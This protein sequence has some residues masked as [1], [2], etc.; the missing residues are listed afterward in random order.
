M[1]DK[2]VITHINV[3]LD[4]WNRYIKSGKALT[5]LIERKCKQ[6]GWNKISD[7]RN[8]ASTYQQVIE[9]MRYI[10][11]E[12]LPKIS[13]LN[14]TVFNPNNTPTS[15]KNDIVVDPDMIMRVVGISIIT[16]NQDVN[17][18]PKDYE[19]N[20]SYEVKK[21][22]AVNLVDKEGITLDH[23]LIK[24]IKMGNS[25]IEYPAWQTAYGDIAMTMYCRKAIDDN[26][27]EE[28]WVK[29]V[30]LQEMIKNNQEFIDKLTRK[31]FVASSVEPEPDAQEEGDYWF[32]PVIFTEPEPVK[33]QYF[34]QSVSDSAKIVIISDD[35]T[36]QY[37]FESVDGTADPIV[38][39]SMG[40]FM[41]EESELA[42]PPASPVP[43]T[44]YLLQSVND[45]SVYTVVDATTIDRYQLESI[46]DPNDTIKPGSL[47]EFQM[48]NV[49]VSN[50]ESSMPVTYMLQ[51]T[52][53]NG[54][55][56][57]NDMSNYQFDP[58]YDGSGVPTTVNGMS[59]FKLESSFSPDPSV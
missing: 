16:D 41:M 47:D 18:P 37:Q 36:G 44:V 57:L 20:L 31:Q 23:V 58:V 30:D 56:I 45:A 38:P 8:L 21:T 26:T 28:D 52:I 13:I 17:T 48:E 53:D 6:M 4:M 33:V 49:E 35:T 29:V 12:I 19:R 50:S 22:S 5:L 51:S 1:D 40:E 9:N 42:K 25:D 46:K 39:S 27:W 10:Q 14:D 59:A 32:E 7:D 43:T 15:G 2:P 55:M 3:K 24:T 54:V 11:D 34:L